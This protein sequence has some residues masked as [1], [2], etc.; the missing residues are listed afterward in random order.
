[1]GSTDSAGNAHDGGPSCGL[2]SSLF[3]SSCRGRAEAFA[4]SLHRRLT[5][6]GGENGSNDDFDLTKPNETSWLH[7]TTIKN[8]TNS[9]NNV[10]IVL[11]HQ[12]RL[13]PESDL[14]YDLEGELEENGIDSPAEEASAAELAHLLVNH[15]SLKINHHDN[16]HA[17]RPAGTSQ[18]SGSDGVYSSPMT[19]NNTPEN[20]ESEIYFD[21]LS[22]DGD[23]KK[24]TFFDPVNSSENEGLS[25]L[26]N[27]SEPEM[28]RVLR[29]KLEKSKHHDTATNEE[30]TSDSSCSLQ[31]DEIEISRLR[32]NPI[33]ST[34]ESSNGRSSID[35]TSHD[36]LWS[37]FDDSTLS[38]NSVKN[39]ALCNQNRVPKSHSDSEIPGM[40]DVS[41]V[42]LSRRIEVL[43]E[44]VDE[45][46]F[47]GNSLQVDQYLK[48]ELNSSLQNGL[49]KID[50]EKEP[51]HNEGDKPIEDTIGHTDHSTYGST[52]NTPGKINKLK[53]TSND[54]RVL[55]NEL[56]LDDSDMTRIS[57]DV[58]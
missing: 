7:S 53:D 35:T 18:D 11:D 52:F 34:D 8:R 57:R 1:M 3:P 37:T 28:I 2:V 55:S 23:K 9:S 51:D 14:F 29:R 49:E 4:R 45:V 21:P 24:N 16:C 58:F 36:S 40:M 48:E 5:S 20:D 47:A 41:D 50:K 13:S 10:K 38:E 44:D 43:E 33:E 27:G 22:S 31:K 32:T 15:Q 39:D 30:E 54:T 6:L 26:S 19:G 12:P 42:R 56:N 17:I 25:T 46:D